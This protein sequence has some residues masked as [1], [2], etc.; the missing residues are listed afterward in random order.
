MI[1]GKPADSAG[2]SSANVGNA[3]YWILRGLPSG[4]PRS[5]LFG[6]LLFV[7]CLATLQLAPGHL[8]SIWMSSPAGDQVV[9]VPRVDQVRTRL[10]QRRDPIVPHRRLE[11]VL[12]DCNLLAE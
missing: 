1:R 6:L 2:M 4:A 7:M 10:L 12:H 8:P 11:F 3:G 9:D 5:F